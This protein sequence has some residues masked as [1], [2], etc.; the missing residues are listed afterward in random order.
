VCV[1][2]S[3]KG[4]KNERVQVTRTPKGHKRLM[5]ILVKKKV[6]GRDDERMPIQSGVTGSGG[7]K[8]T[9]RDRRKK[10]R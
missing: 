3:L 1:V 4:Q 2:A 5:Q 6:K 9:S 8:K 7:V 10:R